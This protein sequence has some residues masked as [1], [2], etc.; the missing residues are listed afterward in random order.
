MKLKRNNGSLPVPLER[1]R[2]RFQQWRETRKPRTRIPDS[3]WRAAVK[4]AGKYGLC[5][6]AQALPVDYYSLKKRMEEHSPAGR[7]ALDCSDAPL[8][9]SV[10]RAAEGREFGTTNTFVELSPSLPASGCDCTLELEDADGSRMRLHWKTAVPPD[11]A[12]LCRSFRNP[13]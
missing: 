1:L 3:L 6:A 4:L 12:S 11:L 13:T 5:R 10:G 7:P 9:R 2:Q 8:A